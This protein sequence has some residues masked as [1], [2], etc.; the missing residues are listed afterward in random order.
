MP[1]YADRYL[2]IFRPLGDSALSRPCTASCS[3]REE[4]VRVNSAWLGPTNCTMQASQPDLG[5]MAGLKQSQH[6]VI[7]FVRK[8]QGPHMLH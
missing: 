7:A 4:G 5:E 2:F 3:V 8:A 6:Y 1:G